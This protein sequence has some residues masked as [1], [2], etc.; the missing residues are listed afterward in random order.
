MNEDAKEL[1][2]WIRKWGP[3]NN[4]LLHL[5]N[6]SH[7][8]YPFAVSISNGG[9]VSSSAPSL[10]GKQSSA[11]VIG[12]GGAEGGVREAAEAAA[13]GV[14]AAFTEAT[15]SS[16]IVVMY[17][18]VY[19]MLST[20]GKVGFWSN[21]VILEQLLASSVS[22]WVMRL[23]ASSGDRL[24]ACPAPLI[25]ELKPR[26]I[27]W[28]SRELSEV[29]E[30]ALET[31]SRPWITLTGVTMV[32]AEA[33]KKRTQVRSVTVTSD[34]VTHERKRLH[35]DDGAEC[36]PKTKTHI[37][38]ETKKWEAEAEEILALHSLVTFALHYHRMRWILRVVFLRV[39]VEMNDIAWHIMRS[40]VLS[41]LNYNSAMIQTVLH[42][43][44]EH[45]V[46]NP[47]G[48]DGS[49][50]AELSQ[51]VAQECFDAVSSPSA[52]L[53][54]LRCLR[55]SD[56]FLVCR[57]LLML[58]ECRAQ[59]ITRL[60]TDRV[61]L[62]NEQHGCELAHKNLRPLL[63]SKGTGTCDKAPTLQDAFG[64]LQN[65][66]NA[67]MR[68][69]TSMM[70]YFGGRAHY[71]DQLS[72]LGRD[73][74]LQAE[75]AFFVGFCKGVVFLKFVDAWALP[76]W[77]CACKEEHDLWLSSTTAHAARW[78]SINEF[79]EDLDGFTGCCSYSKAFWQVGG[80][81]PS[82][83]SYTT[84]N[85]GLPR[86]PGLATLIF[87]LNPEPKVLSEFEA[88]FAAA[89]RRYFEELLEKSHTTG[90]SLRALPRDVYQHCVFLLRLTNQ[91]LEPS[92]SAGCAGAHTALRAVQKGMQNFFLERESCVI[93]TLASALHEQ[94]TRGN[95]HWGA[96][97][98]G[99]TYLEVLD[100]ILE[101]ASLLHSKDLFVNCY[102]GL[103]APRLMMSQQILDVGYGY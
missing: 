57:V 12:Q 97:D 83:N 82:S 92:A 95:S 49:A 5:A 88:C 50:A 28:E 67:F 78:H 14:A 100:T 98:D 89:V 93:V 85:G 31:N 39:D 66:L 42:R 35:E 80:A 3:I 33:G 22:A 36:N 87:F 58:D 79:A 59:E 52:S 1:L 68:L 63:V 101:L 75:H 53:D 71:A 16:N 20:F 4:S 34:T 2:H 18:L 11:A 72:V 32:D 55:D 84:W 54:T 76:L 44:F 9:A 77:L 60:V 103:L 7:V 30:E 23:C 26:W 61:V 21:V 99:G 86:R 64:A 62:F 81:E 74:F 43:T 48:R 19:D 15:D 38:V 27:W 37:E 102:C 6:N 65:C 73:C 94:V 96:S 8:L 13:E 17:A 41:T 91:L 40:C 25:E 90:T 70:I 24:H 51:A 47:Q 29:W 69:R 56:I 45:C 46:N 10:V